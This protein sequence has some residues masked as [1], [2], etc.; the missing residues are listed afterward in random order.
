EAITELRTRLGNGSP[1]VT[2][3]LDSGERT[4][5]LDAEA[6][7]VLEE[8]PN[9]LGM[10]RRLSVQ[11]IDN[12]ESEYDLQDGIRMVEKTILAAPDNPFAYRALSMG[13]LKQQRL[14]EAIEALITAIRLE[15]A[16]PQLREQLYDLLSRAGRSAEARAVTRGEF[17]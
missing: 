11:L 1:V 14:D 13:Y 4:E 12:A 16:M 6:L 9:L 15:P 5:E 17:P 2:E 10:I 7:A 8:N 3:W